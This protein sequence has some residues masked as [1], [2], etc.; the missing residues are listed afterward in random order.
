MN[1]KDVARMWEE[2]RHRDPEE[3]LSWILELAR[4]PT[5]ESIEVLLDVLEQE[6]WFLRDQAARVLATLGEPVVEPLIE[7]LGSGLWYTRSAAASA[8]GR[9]GLPVAAA[10]L[11][12]LLRDANRTVRDA[13]WDALVALAQSE[14]G[15][16]AVADAFRE[17]PERAQRFALDGIA[18]R[19]SETFDRVVATLGQGAPRAVGAGDSASDEAADLS[20]SDVVGESERAQRVAR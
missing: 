12:A 18:A 20:W 10:P 9:M 1:P 15:A 13:T 14:V 6:S 4:N 2:L 7:L 5:E 8:L 11:T 17:L 3:K 19:D 16:H